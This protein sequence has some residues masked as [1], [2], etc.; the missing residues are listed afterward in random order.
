MEKLLNNKPE[1]ALK[2]VAAALRETRK[3]SDR[4]VKEDG[5]VLGYWQTPEFIEYLLELADECDRVSVNSLEEG[6]VENGQVHFSM[7]GFRTQLSEDV[8]ELRDLVVSVVKDEW[9][10]K[11]DLTSKMNDVICKSNGFN[12]VSLNGCDS[13]SNLSSI[14]VE[15]IDLEGC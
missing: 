13:F 15:L 12:C 3:G 6:E 4:A 11:D 8:K 5:E 2:Q 14:E 10:E 1:V 7:D 9:F